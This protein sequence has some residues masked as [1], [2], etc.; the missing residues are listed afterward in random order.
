MIPLSACSRNRQISDKVVTIQITTSTPFEK[1]S[2][3]SGP[4]S[5]PF[6][7]RQCCVQWSQLNRFPRKSLEHGSR[8][9]RLV[10][11]IVRFR[12]ESL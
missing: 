9:P 5:G 4:T 2:P 8:C 6:L 1:S 7:S 11:E 12:T 3:A 10:A